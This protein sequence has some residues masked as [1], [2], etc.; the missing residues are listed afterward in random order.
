MNAQECGVM[1]RNQ[2]QT[3]YGLLF[4][5]FTLFSGPQTPWAS[6]SSP[7]DI[8]DPFEK[9]N[10]RLFEANLVLDRILLEPLA[11]AY[12]KG[13]PLYTQSGLHGVFQNLK[14][15]I[16][17]LSYCI[18][19]KPQLALQTTMRFLINNTFG[20]F[21]FL[22][23]GEAL[24]LDAPEQNY[25]HALA[26]LGV[27]QGP[28]LMLPIFGPSSPRDLASKVGNIGLNPTTSLYARQHQTRDTLKV[29]AADLVDLRSQNLKTARHLQQTSVDFYATVRSIFHQKSRKPAFHQGVELLEEGPQ[30]D[31][32]D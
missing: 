32:D 26:H 6:S 2:I 12:H 14:E 7:S 5:I 30:P 10:R 1:E 15:P 29:T 3:V 21:G 9:M 17:F 4:C 11:T 23:L 31:N 22:R 19:G 16:T 28:Y 27:A 24:G 8:S 13:T 25:G 18:Q 20:L